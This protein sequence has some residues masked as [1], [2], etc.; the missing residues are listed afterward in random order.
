[1]KPTT[2]LFPLAVLALGLHTAAP[3]ALAQTTAAAAPSPTAASASALPLVDAEIRRVDPAAGK[4]TLKH[5]DIPNLD[6]TG[7]TMVF[8]AR[9]PTQLNGLKVG[10]KVR[11]RA[12]VI[13]GVYTAIDIIPAP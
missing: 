9:Q 5:G 13:N 8:V 7:M 4:V 12:D 11:F 6:M 2:S 10:D 3:A 1:M